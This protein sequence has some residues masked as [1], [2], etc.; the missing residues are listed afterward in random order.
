MA[1]AVSV[2]EKDY[3]VTDEQMKNL[4]DTIPDGSSA[5]I[6]LFEHVWA[7]DL[8]GALREHGGMLLSQG[9]ITPESLVSLGVDLAVLAEV[10]ESLES[11]D[12]S[13]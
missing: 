1:G 4:G 9:M 2:A 11:E 10:A 7:K 8:K 3:G 12:S 13:N 6:L 5:L